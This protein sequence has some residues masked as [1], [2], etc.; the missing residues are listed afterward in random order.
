[1]TVDG[2]FT[3]WSAVTDTVTDPTG[4]AAAI[5]FNALAVISDRD[6]LFV[7]IELAEE[8]GLQEGNNVTLYIDTDQDAATGQ[9]IQGMGADLVWQ[10]GQREGTFNGQEINHADIGLVTAP[11]VSSSAFEFKISRVQMP[12][13]EGDSVRLL[14]VEDGTSG[15]RVPDHGALI[16]A[17]REVFHPYAPVALEKEDTNYLRVMSYNVLFNGLTAPERIPRFSR[18]MQALQPDV[19]A[20]NELFETEANE[21][22]D[23]LDEHLPLATTNGWY[24]EKVD[25]G[26][27]TASR[28]PITQTWEVYPGR[29]ISAFLI[30]L[31]GH[32]PSDLLAINAHLKCCNADATRQDEADA[33]AAFYRDIKSPGGD[34]ELPE[35][36]PFILIGDLNLVGDRQQLETLKTGNIID[37]QQ[38]GTD[39]YPDWDQS[40]LHDLR[41]YHSDAR[42]TY[43]WWDAGSS[44]Y[45]GRLDYMIYT[46]S[47]LKV[48]KH[49]LLRTEEMD[50][51][52][53]QQYELEQNDTREASDHLPK[54]ADFTFK[55]TTGERSGLPQPRPFK[56]YPNPAGA[57]LN[58]AFKEMPLKAV[59]LELYGLNGDKL[60]AESVTAMQHSIRMSGY[61]AGWYT[62][63]VRKNENVYFQ[64]I[65]KQ[66]NP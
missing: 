24:T 31:P 55:T 22:K 53:L 8:L 64:K 17:F 40:F 57:N 15:D 50:H 21:V 14:L 11:T 45:P 28:Y 32:Y 25:Y 65:L 23:F 42:E 44:F 59:A 62:L 54:V 27:V 63:L 20:F 2:R 56:V 30:D 13:F 35:N 39:E 46:E 58:I 18:I 66:T 9:S 10:L 33:I 7:R 52:R 19:I 29:R 48:E 4:D 41:S 47:V 36:T 34:I 3:D 5:D 61:P 26:N 38:Y 60:L 6:N 43:T 1:M 37:E 12:L 51:S 16:H 49:F